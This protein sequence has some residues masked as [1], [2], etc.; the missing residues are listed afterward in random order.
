MRR[1]VGEEK[2][3]KEG[4]RDRGKEIKRRERGREMEGKEGKG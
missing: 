2:N 4:V 3:G 1:W